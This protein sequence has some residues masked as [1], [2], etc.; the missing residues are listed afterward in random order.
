MAYETEYN[1]M[2]EKRYYRPTAG[3]TNGTAKH[4]VTIYPEVIL[5]HV[6]EK[7]RHF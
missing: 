6:Y 7:S 4:D 2:A 3:V 5:S 1:A